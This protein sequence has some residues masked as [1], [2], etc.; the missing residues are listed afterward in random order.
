MT[1]RFVQISGPS[2]RNE[3]HGSLVRSHVR[4]HTLTQQ[5]RKAV[6]SWRASR[7]ATQPCVFTGD[8]N[9]IIY[10]N[11]ET[12]EIYSANGPCSTC[13]GLGLQKQSDSRRAERGPRS[14]QSPQGSRALL[15]VLEGSPL[16]APTRPCS[17]FDPFDAI[18]ISMSGDVEILLYHCK[19]VVYYR[20]DQ[21]HA[22]VLTHGT[23]C[24]RS[25]PQ[26]G[27]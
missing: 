7:G 17:S 23:R 26:G 20:L 3:H 5:R 22:Q 1:F 15:G 27:L 12:D 25:R 24:L 13:V 8:K 19:F 11:I 18:P 9:D 21:S 10:D 4:R 2:G 14:A 16:S 6:P